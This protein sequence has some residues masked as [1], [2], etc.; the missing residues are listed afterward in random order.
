MTPSTNAGQ[1]PA[2]AVLQAQQST[3]DSSMRDLA[4]TM[5]EGFASMNTKMDR[6]GDI[7]LSLA[8]MAARQE[9]HSDGLQRAFSELKSMREAADRQIADQADYAEKQAEVHKT[10]DNRLNTARGVA[11]GVMFAWTALVGLLTWGATSYISETRANTEKIHAIQLENA[12]IHG[13]VPP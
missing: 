1:D 9:A 13:R 5:S 12:R 7:S 11:I 2:V 4:R 10:I 6:L 8:G 3:L